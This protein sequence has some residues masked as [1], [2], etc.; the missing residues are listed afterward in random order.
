M[1]GRPRLPARTATRSEQAT[2]ADS[3][4]PERRGG[5]VNIPQVENLRPRPQTC[6][7]F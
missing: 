7:H 2:R 3:G 5:L 1:A 4:S 6:G